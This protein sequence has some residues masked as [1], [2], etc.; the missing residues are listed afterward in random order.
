MY[1]QDF[2]DIMDKINSLAKSINYTNGIAWAKAATENNRLNTYDY[3]AFD[4]CHHLR[5]LMAHGFARDIIIS[6]ETM[7]IARMFHL[8]IRNDQVNTTAA[9][10]AF[11]AKSALV[12][13]EERQR[14]LELIK[15][16]PIT[17]VDMEIHVG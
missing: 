3:S 7:Q 11:P 14:K 15:V 17:K 2:I 10:Q 4:G 5:N 12:Q 8:S 13:E 16:M 9:M 6:N 1:N